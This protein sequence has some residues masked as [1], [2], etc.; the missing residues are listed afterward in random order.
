MDE[1]RKA[2]ES[3]AKQLSQGNPLAEDFVNTSRSPMSQSIQARDLAEDALANQVLKN[4]GVPIPNAGASQLKQEDF[5]NRILQERYPELKSEVNFK[6]LGTNLGE[7]NDG[8]ISLNKKLMGDPIKSL[9]TGLHEA[10]H[11]Y[12]DKILKFDGTDDIAKKQLITNVP[13]GRMLQDIDPM[14]MA[15]IVNKGHH[16][17]IPNLRDADSFG[18]GALKSMMKSGTFKGIAP[19]LGKAALTG[20]GGLASLAAEA[21][22]SEEAGDSMDDKMMI[23][24]LNARKNYENSPAYGDKRGFRL[25][26]QPQEDVIAEDMREETRTNLDPKI[27]ALM[28]LAGKK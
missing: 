12:D 1:R 7:Y 5:L 8:K 19:V 15:E 4:T 27:A 26:Q 23:N 3:Y 9:S 6:D 11:G 28:K 10:G 22:D 18:L 2:L 24:E 20:A 14:Q 17:R 13:A 21:A 25:G 16:A